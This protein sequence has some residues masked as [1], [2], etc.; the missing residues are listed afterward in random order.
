VTRKATR[1]S[2]LP[3]HIPTPYDT[4]KKCGEY[5]ADHGHNIAPF[6]TAAG[7]PR[8]TRG[9][10][11][12]K[13]KGTGKGRGKAKAKVSGAVPKTAPETDAKTLN[14]VMVAISPNMPTSSSRAIAYINYPDISL[15][16]I[17]PCRRHYG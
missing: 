15:I 7:R 10:L 9:Q 12:G 14:G 13:A 8:R 11:A 6:K 5:S 17:E 16:G 2:G 1:N 3:A 4:V